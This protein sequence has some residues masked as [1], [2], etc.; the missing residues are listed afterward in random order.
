MPYTNVCQV[1]DETPLTGSQPPEED[2]SDP[3]VPGRLDRERERERERE[4]AG[5]EHDGSASGRH[6]S[7]SLP[8]LV[9]MTVGIHA[10]RRHHS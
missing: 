1:T 3:K 4:T 2:G 8:K 7:L 9:I 5:L 10:C 6:R